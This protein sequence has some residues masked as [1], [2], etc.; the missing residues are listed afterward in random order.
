MTFAV[1]SEAE[2]NEVLLGL[3]KG[4]A[5]LS[6][7]KGQINI[8]RKTPVPGLET[9]QTLIK[10]VKDEKRV[11]C[12]TETNMGNDLQDL[13]Q[14]SRRFSGASWLRN[15][16]PSVSETAVWYFDE[17]GDS[18]T[19]TV[20]V[21]STIRDFETDEEFE[22]EED[23]MIADNSV[24]S[25]SYGFLSVSLP[26]LHKSDDTSPLLYDD[27]TDG[28]FSSYFGTLP[29]ATR[30]L[31]KSELYLS[32]SESQLNKDK[33]KFLLPDNWRDDNVFDP[34]QFGLLDN[35]G[36]LRMDFDDYPDA[37]TGD[38]EEEEEVMEEDSSVSNYSLTGALGKTMTM[39]DL[40][41]VLDP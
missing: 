3:R 18:S 20:S 11:S 40:R 16:T 9:E 31:F 23:D 6:P 39:S 8:N 26:R 34:G 21:T 37:V 29:R 27:T 4:S 36:V 2:G 35:P 25:P 28:S 12:E 41:V 19:D 14:I 13:F 33:L 5:K 22:E 17:P 32:K 30:K 15:S 24:A 7:Q 1:F 10:P 38:R